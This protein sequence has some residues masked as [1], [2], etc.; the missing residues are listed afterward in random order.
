MLNKTYKY[1]LYPTTTQKR[2]LQAS[3]DACRWAYN[4][5]LEIR[6]EAWGKEQKSLSLYDTNRLLIQWKKD[7]PDLNNAHSQCLQNAQLRVDLAF[8]AF[9]RHV[10]A[11]EKPGY[12]RF[13]G[14]D[15]YDSFTFPQSGFSLIGDK[16]KLSKID[17]IKV[18]KHRNIE[19][20]IKTLTIRRTSTGKWYACFSCE[21]IPK[22]LRKVKKVVGIDVGL[23]SFATFSTGEKIKNPRFFR[24]DET[25]LAKIQR[26]LSKAE[27]GSFDRKKQRKKIAH[28]HERI[29][30]R[31]KDFAHQLSRELVNK[32]QVI[33]F[34]KLN[35][36]N[37]RENGFKGIRKSIGDVA[38]SQFMQFTT[39]KAEYAGRQVMYVDPRN[40]SKRCSRCGQIVEKKLSDRVH[41]CSCGL[42]LNRDHNAAINILALGLQGLALA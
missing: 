42:V 19:G 12:P 27:K 3:L 6:K 13:Q 38:W 41:H 11:G 31:R 37:M 4:K 7:N 32:Y 21:I 20:A 29:A 28:C 33:A 8:K 34:E 36:K 26:R 30:N 16:V 15:R 10:K 9:F 23:E 39:Y 14:F 5:T 40:T 1:R 35:I 18:C 22:P 24:T 17:S 25:K 2:A